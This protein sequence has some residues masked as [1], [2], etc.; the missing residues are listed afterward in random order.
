MKKRTKKTLSVALK[1]FPRVL[2]G[3]ILCAI[4]HVSMNVI[5]VAFF[6]DIVGYQLNLLEGR[7]P[8]TGHRIAAFDCCIQTA[9]HIRH[10][11]DDEVLLCRLHFNTVVGAIPRDNAGILFLHH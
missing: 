4:M 6:S 3:M 9:D 2:V 10:G 1:L 5:S 7:K 11:R 8:P